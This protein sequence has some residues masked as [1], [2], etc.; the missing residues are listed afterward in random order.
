M[1]TAMN[2]LDNTMQVQDN[3]FECSHELNMEKVAELRD[4]GLLFDAP[5]S[6]KTL[7][8]N[9]TKI[10]FIKINKKIEDNKKEADKKLNENFEKNNDTYDTNNDTIE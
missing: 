8:S 9:K 6:C 1:E 3:H 4:I 5:K 10:R 2:N 7:L